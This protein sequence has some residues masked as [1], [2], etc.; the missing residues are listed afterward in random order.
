VTPA[1]RSR[2]AWLKRRRSRRKYR[3]WFMIG[4]AV[5]GFLY[6]IDPD[7]PMH[8]RRLVLWILTLRGSLRG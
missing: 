4:S 8:L 3:H 2:I 7:F 6:A 5:V 1:N